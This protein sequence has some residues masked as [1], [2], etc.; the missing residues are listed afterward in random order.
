MPN[1][2][3][4]KKTGL[5]WLGIEQYRPRELKIL[6]FMLLTESRLSTPPTWWTIIRYVFNCIYVYWYTH[7]LS[8]KYPHNCLCMD[9]TLK[10]KN[11]SVTFVYFVCISLQTQLSRFF[12]AF[13]F[14]LN[15][16]FKSLFETMTS[17]H[18]SLNIIYLCVCI[19]GC[20]TI[21]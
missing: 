18:L 9:C 3:N 6:S 8:L 12:F 17:S 10:T 7:I 20:V 4:G 1:C 19:T 14:E 5:F 13:V 16:I 15:L 2:R 11:G 21:D